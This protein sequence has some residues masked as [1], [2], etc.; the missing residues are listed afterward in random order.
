MIRYF[1]LFWVVLFVG[2]IASPVIVAS[3]GPEIQVS[4]EEVEKDFVRYEEGRGIRVGDKLSFFGYGELH[5]ND[6]IG[7]STGDQFD[8]HRM[9]IGIGIDFTDWLIFRTEIDFEHAATEIELELAYLDFLIS[10]IFNVRMGSILVPVGFLNTHHEL[11]FYYSVERPQ[12]NTVII[13]TSWMAAGAGFHGKTEFGLEYQ[14][15]IME[16]LDAVGGTFNGGFRGDRGLRNGRRKVAEAAGRDVAGVLRLD[17]KGIKG[18]QI[19]T[20]VWLG[21]TGQGS[22][23]VG[24]GLT[25][26]IEG[27]IRF[28]IEGFEVTG[29]GAWVHIADAAGINAAI[30]AIDPTTAFT[31]FVASDIIGLYGEV[32]YHLFHHLWPNS[33]Y[34][35]VVFGRHERYNTQHNM[36]AG[37]AAAAANDRHTTT[38]GIAFYPIKQVALKFDYSFNR[39][40]AGTA[41]DQ[42]NAGF[43]FIY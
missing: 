19:G 40:Q 13:P 15:Y 33:P 32:A 34:D 41:N 20:S 17:Y 36:P 22:G 9:V 1:Y 37:F 14:A 21:N 31:N 30:Q 2:L 10:D 39:N 43:A 35:L 29:V 7:T 4:D 8:F 38:A 3:E 16:S 23:V 11:T 6:P 5:Y 25:S 18:L 28:Q 26:I 12:F 42:F 24:G 27:D